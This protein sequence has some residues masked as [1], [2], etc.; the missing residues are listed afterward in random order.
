MFKKPPNKMHEHNRT[1][2]KFKYVV[3][4]LKSEQHKDTQNTKET[5]P[6]STPLSLYLP[7]QSPSVFFSSV[8]QPYIF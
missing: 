5:T 4:E 8:N 7:L 2:F 1:F 6:T 3:Q